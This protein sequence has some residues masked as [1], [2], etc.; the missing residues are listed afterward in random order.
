[1]ANGLVPRTPALAGISFSGSVQG[2][3]GL[4]CMPLV[5]AGRA[6]LAPAGWP[7]TFN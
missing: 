6:R 4:P 1:M 3:L 2:V 5:P 7:T